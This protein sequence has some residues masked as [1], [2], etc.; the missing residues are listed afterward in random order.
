MPRDMAM[1][2]PRA[3]VAAGPESDDEPPE[4]RQDCGIA[5]RGVVELEMRIVDDGIEEDGTARVD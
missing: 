2:H 3:G 4:G 1:E 5:P